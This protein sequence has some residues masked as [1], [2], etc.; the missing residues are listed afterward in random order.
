[1][2]FETT[3]LSGL[4]IITPDIF[5]DERGFFVKIWNR[6][7]FAKNGVTSYFFEDNQ[8][9]S[10]KNVVRGLHFQWEPPLGKLMR[11][12]RGRA[13]AA[14]VDIRKKSPTLGKWFGLEL[15]EENKLMLF[16]PSGFAGGFAALE[17]ETNVHYKYTAPH[18]PE[19]ESV[20]AWNDPEIGIKWP[21]SGTP[22]LSERDGQ[23][24]SLRTWLARPES[25]LF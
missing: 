5:P 9:N 10:K 23:A 11:V 18:N 24:K 8:S 4:M 13:F 1:M 6:D 14:A 12:V 7:I 25:N 22:I 15:S 2:K 20:I 21:I 16:A 19:G 17:D 3:P